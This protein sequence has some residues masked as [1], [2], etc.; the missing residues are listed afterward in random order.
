M[1][2]VLFLFDLADGSKIYYLLKPYMYSIVE[3]KYVLRN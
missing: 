3:S 1:C 2:M